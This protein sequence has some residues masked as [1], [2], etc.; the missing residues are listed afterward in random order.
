MMQVIGF[1]RQPIAR[2]FLPPYQLP[3]IIIIIRLLVLVSILDMIDSYVGHQVCRQTLSILR[4]GMPFALVVT[5][6]QQV[7]SRRMFQSLRL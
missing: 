2:A 7:P 6:I 5:P 3:S 4:A 1:Y